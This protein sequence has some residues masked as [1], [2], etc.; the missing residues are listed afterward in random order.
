M[1]GFSWPCGCCETWCDVDAGDLSFVNQEL[2]DA[3]YD[4]VEVIAF[5]VTSYTATSNQITSDGHSVPLPSGGM[6]LDTPCREVIVSVD[7]TGTGERGVAYIHWLGLVQPQDD[8]TQSISLEASV[9]SLSLDVSYKNDADQPFC[10]FVKTD[11]WIMAIPILDKHGSG[12]TSEAWKLLS[13]GTGDD[14]DTHL[15]FDDVLYP[16][17]NLPALGNEFEYGWGVITHTTDLATGIPGG[18]SYT[19]KLGIHARID[20]VC[21]NINKDWVCSFVN[22]SHELV[23]PSMSGSCT[24]CSSVS[25]VFQLDPFYARHQGP[26]CVSLAVIGLVGSCT[27][28]LTEKPDWYDGSLPLSTDSLV[29]VITYNQ[30]LSGVITAVIK[31]GFVRE[32]SGYEDYV[33]DILSYDIGYD[34]LCS[35]FDPTDDN[36]FTKRYA[37]E[38]SSTCTG[39]PS[40]LTTTYV[41]P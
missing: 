39:W 2:P 25:G 8:I 5:G 7:D 1:V 38:C 31:L 28:F 18:A 14:I 22:H 23:V 37:K 32:T 19:G 11:D 3:S 21:L 26:E 34:Y 24:E 9:K 4:S 27:C 33:Y 20:N 41:T 35:D 40:T 12:A 6:S 36:V 30:T 10:I 29:W 17:R 15:I 16:N 13:G